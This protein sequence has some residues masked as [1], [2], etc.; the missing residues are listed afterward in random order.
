MEANQK[1]TMMAISFESV[2]IDVG[3]SKVAQ[4]KSKVEN[5]KKLKMRNKN[6]D[7]SENPSPPPV[8]PYVSKHF[9]KKAS[10]LT[11]FVELRKST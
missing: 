1:D 6:K 2:K 3:E 11:K 9:L 8:K 7:D 5:E 4:D 10:H